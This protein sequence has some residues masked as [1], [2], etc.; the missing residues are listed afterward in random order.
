MSMP[1]ARTD[2]GAEYLRKRQKTAHQTGKSY[3]QV[4]VSNQ[5]LVSATEYG[6]NRRAPAFVARL[7]TAKYLKTDPLFKDLFFPLFTFKD[8]FGFCSSSFAKDAWCASDGL[9]GIRSGDTA[10]IE[11]PVDKVQWARAAAPYRG[12][13]SFTLR[14]SRADTTNAAY[15]LNNEDELVSATTLPYINSGGVWAPGDT[16]ETYGIH[17]RFINGPTLG[18]SGAARDVSMTNCPSVQMTQIVDSGSIPE[19]QQDKLR[20][21]EL[22]AIVNLERKAI[23]STPFH[24]NLSGGSAQ[25]DK[26]SDGGSATYNWPGTEASPNDLVTPTTSDVVTQQRDYYSNLRDTT[27]R[28]A[29]GYLE[30]DITNGKSAAA[31]IEVVIH[32][33]KSHQF[34]LGA[35]AIYKA[36][37]DAVTYQ[38][39]DKPLF[40]TGISAG[41]YAGGW[42]CLY[43]PGYPLLH[44]GSKHKKHIDN[45]CNEVHR[46]S[47]VLAP[48]QSKTIKIFLG[49]LYYNL[50]NKCDVTGLQEVDPTAGS[51]GS[52]FPNPHLGVGALQV[53][54]GH[55]GFKQLTA[56]A[57]TGATARDD[58]VGAFDFANKP[59]NY[60]GTI[61]SMSANQHSIP[62]AGFWIGKQYAPSEIICDG[63][64]C[65]KFYPMYV[66]S[67]QRSFGQ[68]VAN[69]PK[70]IGKLGNTGSDKRLLLPSGL[71]ATDIVSVSDIGNDSV[72]A[73]M[74]G[75][76]I[77]A[78]SVSQ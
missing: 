5:Q 23:L 49:N 53:T 21:M 18:G 1:F 45:I 50:G 24:Y 2:G 47:H 37:W 33:H 40:D 10:N 15:K 36:I 9:N 19:A 13:A 64:Y 70:C 34:D 74:T 59:D 67:A 73:K 44:V 66:Q 22:S 39:R 65:E 14:S 30:M 35:D 38:Q 17:R 78:L 20:C 76:D 68:F 28:I 4:L 8:C 46:S 77:N 32:S 48:G 11:K 6:M 51:Y 3:N 58:V 29:D 55:S 52:T 26:A 16:G 57:V 27:M 56:P 43:D 63:K 69:P 75:P 12:I 54:I 61:S 62:H 60:S 42:Q 41:T 71:P 25:F 7:H 72:A 31:L